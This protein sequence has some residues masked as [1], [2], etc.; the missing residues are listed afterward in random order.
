[1]SPAMT[2]AQFEDRVGRFIAS[3]FLPAGAVAPGPADDLFGLLDSLQVL[4]TVAWVEETF[5]VKV[6]DADLTAENLGT[7][8]R[9]AAFVARTASP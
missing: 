7:V 1:V 9:I 6:G 3:S 5:G 2:A 4:R 8:G